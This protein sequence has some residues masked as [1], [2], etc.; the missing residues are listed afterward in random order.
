MACCQRQMIDDRFDQDFVAKKVQQYRRSGLKK[1]T[2]ILV[3]ALKSEG[4]D[5]LTL[6]DVGGGLGT[7]AHELM[8]AGVGQTVSVEAS[9]AFIDAAQT[10]AARQGLADKMTFMHGDLVELTPQVPRADVVT[11]DKVVCCYRD[12]ESLVRVSVEKAQKLYGLVYPRDN[13]WMKIGIGFENLL[14]NLKGDDWRMYVHPT[15][16]VDRLI[17]E[18]GLR[19]RFRH[20]LID[21]QIVVYGF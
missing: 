15:P 12:M 16:E 18:H 17:R 4:V 7:I 13:W 6:L 8:K 19:Q 3:E 9:Q 21:W 11:L 2:R 1:E 5:G 14:Q 10:E 20:A